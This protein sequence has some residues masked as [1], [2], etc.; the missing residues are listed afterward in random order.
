MQPKINR[1]SPRPSTKVL[2]K[3]VQ[4]FYSNPANQQTNESKAAGQNKAADGAQHTPQLSHLWSILAELAAQI[5]R[6]YITGKREL[7]RLLAV[8]A[9]VLN[10][11]MT[12]V[13]MTQ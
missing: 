2:P 8:D 13:T 3:S 7:G 4:N 12:E 11:V 10:Q 5:M 6:K 1:F 9:V